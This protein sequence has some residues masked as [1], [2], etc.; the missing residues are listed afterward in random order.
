MTRRAAVAAVIGFACLTSACLKKETT[1]TVYIAADGSIQWTVD[2]ANVYSDETDIGKRLAEEEAY[3]GAALTGVHRVALGLQA[4]KPDSLVGTTVLRDERPFHVI[5]EARFAAIDSAFQR[6]FDETGFKAI[7]TQR[8]D[9]ARS[10]LRMHFD[11][12]KETQEKE[13]AAVALLEEIGSLRFV[14]ADG[15]FVGGG[16]FD[17]TDRTNAAAISPEWMAAAEKAMEAHGTI[18]LVLTWESGS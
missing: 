6:L 5:T 1:Q 15:R 12:T 16:G 10:T 7:V 2:E 18:D 8:R 3:I 14:L 11:F 17:I 4:L 13:S 9:D